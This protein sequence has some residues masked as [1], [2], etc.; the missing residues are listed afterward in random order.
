MEFRLD[1]VEAYKD[2]CA[3]LGKTPRRVIDCTGPQAVWVSRNPDA[4][5][6]ARTVARMNEYAKT[7]KDLEFGR[8]ETAYDR[9]YGDPKIKPNPNLAPISDS[10]FYA[11]KLHPGD[12][13]TQG[14]LLTDVNGQ[15]VGGDWQPIPSL[16]ATGNCTAAVIPTYPG[17]G[18]TIGPAMVFGYLAAKHMARMSN[19]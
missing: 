10:P 8:G 15:V 14:G 18:A 11:L 5:G 17:P 1:F 2:A 13:G 12:I 16:Y 7:G 19:Q 4:E 9:H 3:A 6:L